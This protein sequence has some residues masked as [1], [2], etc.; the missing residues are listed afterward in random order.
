MNNMKTVSNLW[1]DAV[2]L[3]AYIA[4]YKMLFKKR[5]GMDIV[6]SRQSGFRPVKHYKIDEYEPLIVGWDD[7]T[8]DYPGMF[9]LMIAPADKTLDG[10]V[11]VMK[12]I[13]YIPASCFEEVS[14][15]IDKLIQK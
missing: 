5:W 10:K 14:D 2:N 4:D 3:K 6:L 7:K 9:K 15:H 8:Q 11:K 12:T 13:P 1:L